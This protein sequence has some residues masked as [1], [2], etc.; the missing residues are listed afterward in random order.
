VQRDQQRVPAENHGHRLGLVACSL[1]LESDCRLSDLLRHTR[2]ELFHR[3]PFP[4]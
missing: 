1:L 4:Q 2:I 3:T